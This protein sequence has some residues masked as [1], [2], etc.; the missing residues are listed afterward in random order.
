MFPLLAGFNRVPRAAIGI[1]V[2]VVL[3]GAGSAGVA[4]AETRS[5]SLGDAGPRLAGDRPGAQAG[6]R[7]QVV[8]DLDRDGFDDM[9]VG[10]WSYD[11]S[12]EELDTGA[13][14]VIYG[15]VSPGANLAGA[16]ATLLGEAA[17]AFAGETLAGPAD[18]NG[19]GY[20][21][22]VIGA[23]GPVPGQPG[24]LRPGRAYLIYGGPTRLA[25]TSRLPDVADAF[26][27]GEVPVDNASLDLHADDL[28]GDGIDDLVVGGAGW[29][30]LLGKVW[31]VYGT[32]TRFVGAVRLADASAA[33]FVGEHQASATGF[34]LGS[35]D[36]DGD[37]ATDL[38]IGAHFWGGLKGAAYIV[39]GSL[40]RFSATSSVA[41]AAVRLAGEEPGDTAGTSVA[42][43]DLDG[44]RVA[45]LVVGAPAAAPPATLTRPGTAYVFYGGR[46][47]RLPGSL[48][49]AD[50]AL[51]GEAAGDTA[52]TVSVVNEGAGDGR[53]RLAVGAVG[54]DF[55]GVDAGA[56]YVAALR[57]RGERVTGRIS[58]AT[59]KHKF[60]GEAAGD[61]AGRSRVGVLDAN[62]DGLDDLLIGAEGQDAGGADAGAA[63]LVLGRPRPDTKSTESTR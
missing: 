61:R 6:F 9:V 31:V 25:G 23:P 52:G 19:D 59:A 47:L 32:W 48:A 60:T 57:V 17:G 8:G 50:A 27:V 13:V 51:F 24:E 3:V 11:Y 7:N 58:L 22:L 34:S 28:D 35:D 38:V 29:G 40:S 30:G 43:G 20:D 41:T 16:N 36:L 53:G 10:A 2:L 56:V 21:D 4:T 42:T 15:P 39:Y 46:R 5:V 63:Y 18:V 54:H 37:G 12:P 45:D 33:Q 44:D 26:F 62:A 49:T 14:Y 55:G 1:S